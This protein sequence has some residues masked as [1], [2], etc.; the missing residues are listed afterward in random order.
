VHLHLQTDKTLDEVYGHHIF[1]QMLNIRIKY[2]VGQN[3]FLK[4]AQAGKGA[5]P[6]SFD[7][8]LYSFHSS[9]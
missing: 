8:C 4:F 5:N 6:G 7:F 2:L 1:L 3:L 9:A